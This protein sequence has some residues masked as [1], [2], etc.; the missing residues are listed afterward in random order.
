VLVDADL[1]EWIALEPQGLPQRGGLILFTT[2]AGRVDAVM[3][4]STTIPL[5]WRCVISSAWRLRSGAEVFIV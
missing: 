3:D 5:H 4:R 2:P 1:P